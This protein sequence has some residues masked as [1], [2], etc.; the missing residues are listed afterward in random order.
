V[1]AFI[2]AVTEE[3]VASIVAGMKEVVE[4]GRAAVIGEK[5]S[6]AV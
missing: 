5:F 6:V 1:K 4:R 3:E 2:Y